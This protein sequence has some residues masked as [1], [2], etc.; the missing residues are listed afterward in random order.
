MCVFVTSSTCG[1]F[2]TVEE[3]R[4]PCVTLSFRK[5]PSLNDD[6]GFCGGLTSCLD[7][8]PAP[9]ILSGLVL[10]VTVTEC[11]CVCVCVCV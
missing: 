10:S 8:C 9:V 1:D 2:T 4:E 11:V 3:D 5:A 6:H 7:Q